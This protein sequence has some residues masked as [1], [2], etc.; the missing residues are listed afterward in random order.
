M[1]V[2]SRKRKRKENK[3]KV[4]IEVKVLVNSIRIILFKKVD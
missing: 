4:W 3:V 2:I 1:R